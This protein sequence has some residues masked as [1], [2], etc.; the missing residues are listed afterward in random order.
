MNVDLAGED[1][2]K[3]ETL[4]E[5]C[6]VC[7]TREKALRCSKCKMT[8]YCSKKCQKLH[9]EHHY[10]YCTMIEGLKEVERRKIYGDL[11]VRQIQIND[12]TRKKLVKLVG[13]KPILKCRLGGV[14]VE[15]LWDTGSMVSLVDRRWIKEN[16]PD[17]VIHPVSDFLESNEKE[18]C[19][20]A[21][22]STRIKFDGVAV[23]DF[24]VGDGEGFVVPILVASDDMNEPILGYNVIEYLILNG[25]VEE[26]AAL[27][28]ALKGRNSRWDMELLSAVIEENA[29]NVHSFCSVLT[30]SYFVFQSMVMVGVVLFN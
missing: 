20:R 12:K 23:L 10:P 2:C 29:N 21:A 15:V 4:E 3:E 24:S 11:S 22:N 6:C 19:L 30:S 25:S 27:Q 9:F 18:L 14:E 13:D 1:S 26:R 16:L 28:T 7:G 17:A 5:A 8:Y